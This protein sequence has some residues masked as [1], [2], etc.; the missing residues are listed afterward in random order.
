[1]V[2]VGIHL[3]LMKRDLHCTVISKQLCKG[4][5]LDHPGGHYISFGSGFQHPR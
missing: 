5:R 1:M 3:K 2:A 4:V